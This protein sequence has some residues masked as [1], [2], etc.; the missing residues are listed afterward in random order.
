MNGFGR[1]GASGSNDRDDR[2]A[3]RTWHRALATLKWN[4]LESGLLTVFWIVSTAAAGLPRVAPPEG[5]LR[6]RST[7]SLPPF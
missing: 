5:L 6:V 4:W 1:A 3:G 7:V 2:R